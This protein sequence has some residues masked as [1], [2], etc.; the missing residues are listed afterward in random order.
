MVRVFGLLIAAIALMAPANAALLVRYDFSGNATGTTDPVLT[1]TGG[2]A[3]AF[4]GTAGNTTGTT[5]FAGF[6]PDTGVWRTN[7]GLSTG[8]SNSFTITAGSLPVMV[9]NILFSYRRQSPGTT[10]VTGDVSYTIGAGAPVSLDPFTAVNGVNTYDAA[11][12]FSFLLGAGESVTFNINYNT[13]TNGV[14]FGFVELQGAVV[15]EP[16]SI[17]VFG[18]LA[19]F[20][21]VRRYRRK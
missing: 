9:D 16:A 1:A 6:A 12:T 18:S 8:Q 17:A 2:T 20:G 3:S 19:A 10:N 21:L 11:G 4:G 5:S 15:P 14:E 13:S 7:V